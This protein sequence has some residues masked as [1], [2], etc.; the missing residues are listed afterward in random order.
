MF[1]VGVVT[2]IVHIGAILT[3]LAWGATGV[4]WGV[5]IASLVAA[6]IEL[7]VVGRVLQLR[8]AATLRA[9]AS[10]LLLAAVMGV[11]VWFLPPWVG[12][13]RSAASALAA[14]IGVGATIYVVGARFATRGAYQELRGIV[15]RR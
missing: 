12:L 11:I 4:A 6:P 15:R 8:R 2:G 10:N 13:D 7:A 9:V 1:G 14:Q 5:M 3:G